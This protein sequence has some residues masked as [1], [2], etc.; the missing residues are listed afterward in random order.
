[1]VFGN[2]NT[3]AA[4]KSHRENSDFPLYQTHQSKGF[5]KDCCMN[6]MFALW[7][8]GFIL[9]H[10]H[11]T[12]TKEKPRSDFLKTLILS[13]FTTLCQYI[14]ASGAISH[15]LSW[16]SYISFMKLSRLFTVPR[17]KHDLA[18][19]HFEFRILPTEAWV[20]RD[21]YPSCLSL[22]FTSLFLFWGSRVQTHT[23][24]HTHHIQHFPDRNAP[25]SN[26]GIR[27]KCPGSLETSWPG[28]LQAPW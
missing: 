23:L 17:C 18:E 14:W 26:E 12:E 22:S 21:N 6:V 2:H 1:M 16:S 27:W 4:W 25:G 24:T 15:F 19:N 20:L 28:S 9:G 8:E 5:R 13:Y 3:D 11:H 10:M 7:L